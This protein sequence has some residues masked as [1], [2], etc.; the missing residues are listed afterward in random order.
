MNV[1]DIETKNEEEKK[2]SLAKLKQELE[3]K[4]N[5]INKDIALILGG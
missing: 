3:D 2:I 1:E 5:R 4:L